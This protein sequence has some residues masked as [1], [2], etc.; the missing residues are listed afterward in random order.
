MLHEFEEQLPDASSNRVVY[1]PVECP[2]CKRLRLEAEIQD[3]AIV[4]VKCEKCGWTPDDEDAIPNRAAD[5]VEASDTW[6]NPETGRDVRIDEALHV[7]DATRNRAIDGGSSSPMTPGAGDATQGAKDGE[8]GT[9]T[10]SPP[11]L[12]RMCGQEHEPCAP[13][14]ECNCGNKPCC[15][16]EGVYTLTDWQREYVGR[17]TRNR[18]AELADL[19]RP[20]LNEWTDE[21]GNKFQR[22]SAGNRDTAEAMADYILRNWTAT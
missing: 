20:A 5:D 16:S 17:V 8:P 21:H 12:C 14:I 19:L 15:H 7:P 13:G 4:W 3:N 11:P 10:D 22:F 1:L 9:P 18:V 6:T 2:R